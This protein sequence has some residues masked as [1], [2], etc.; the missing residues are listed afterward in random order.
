MFGVLGQ[1]GMKGWVEEK[2]ESV[3]FASFRRPCVGSCLGFPPLNPTHQPENCAG[4][5]SR[6]TPLFYEPMRATSNL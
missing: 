1:G 3:R 4:A 5:K 6:M 2:L